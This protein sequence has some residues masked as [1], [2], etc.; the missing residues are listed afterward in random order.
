M[1]AERHVVLEPDARTHGC[2]IHF[3]FSWW[4]GSQVPL[5]NRRR[6]TPEDSPVLGIFKAKK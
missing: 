6:E 2:D 5:A 4:L 1:T 3:H